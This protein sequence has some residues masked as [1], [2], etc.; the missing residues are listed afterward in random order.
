MLYLLCGLYLI[1]VNLPSVIINFINLITAQKYKCK[2][3]I[4]YKSMFDENNKI[5]SITQTHIDMSLAQ[6][7]KQRMKYQYH[8]T[9]NDYILCLISHSIAT[10]IKYDTH[11]SSK[12]KLFNPFYIPVN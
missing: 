10:L 3:Y 5:S 4:Q 8:V 6:I 11:N 9:V 2:E 12:A 1:L 7:N